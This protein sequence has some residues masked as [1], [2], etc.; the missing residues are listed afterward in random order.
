MPKRYVEGKSG[1]RVKPTRCGAS[2]SCSPLWRRYRHDCSTGNAR[3]WRRLH[4]D[5]ERAW[6]G[7]IP[8]DRLRS[9][10]RSAGGLGWGLR[11][12]GPMAASQGRSGG[13]SGFIEA[14]P[15]RVA[16]SDRPRPV[17]ACLSSRSDGR[18]YTSRHAP[19]QSRAVCRDQVGLALAEH[20]AASGPA[21]RLA[22]LNDAP[23]VAAHHRSEADRRGHQGAQLIKPNRHQSAGHR[24]AGGTPLPHHPA[25]GRPAEHRGDES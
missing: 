2:P 6:A 23:G 15:D 17:R 7:I 16:A 12:V 13:G 5:P 11:P 3:P 14:G 21:A 24:P 18:V 8:S 10:P 9:R 25:P 1:S 19:G 20:P 22:D 4:N